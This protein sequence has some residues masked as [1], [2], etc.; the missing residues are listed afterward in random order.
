MLLIVVLEI[1]LWVVY[2][3]LLIVVLEFFFGH[4]IVLDAFEELFLKLITL[5]FG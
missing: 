2:D 3:A 1:G 5:L 4:R